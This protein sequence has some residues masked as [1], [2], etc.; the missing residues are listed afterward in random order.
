M[1]EPFPACSAA[2]SQSAEFSIFETGRPLSFLAQSNA[3]FSRLMPFL[4]LIL[5][6]LTLTA[7][8]AHA[9]LQI[10]GRTYLRSPGESG[11]SGEWVLYEKNAPRNEASRR[12]LT[13]KVL[14]QLAGAS[15]SSLSRLP[16]VTRTEARG[17]YAVVTFSGDATAA[18]EGAKRLKRLPGI[19]SAEPMLARQ[20]QPRLVPDDPYFAYN[21]SNPG[22]QWHLRN[23]GENG[24]TAGIDLNVVNTWDAFLGGGIRIGIL[25]DGLETAH[26][27]LAPNI[28]LINDRD[29]N[30]LDDDPSPG[31]G[32]FHGT[33][34]AGVAAARGSNGVGVSG[35]APRATLVGMRLIAAPTTDADE[36]DAFAFRNDIIQVKSSSWGPFDNAFGYGGP[37]V[38]SQA[39]LA[40]AAATGRGGLGTVF[41]WAAGNGN[42]SG[43]DSN[44][45]G[46]AASPY[47]I[48]VSAIRDNGQASSYS[49]PGANIL[50]CAPSNG[51]GQGVTTTDIS[52]ASGYNAGTGQDYSNGDYTLSFGGT[53]SATP[54][55]AGVVALMLQAN[56]GLG[57]RDVQEILLSSATK[58]DA[59]DGGW[60]TNGAGFSF[61]HRYG[62]GLVNA[63]AATTMAQGWTNL[64]PRE[65]RT[66]SAPALNLAIPDGGQAGLTHTFTVDAADNLRLEHVTVSVKATHP[67]RGQLEWWL[68]SPSGVSVRLARARGNDTGAN[69]DWTFMTTH[70]WG[71]RSEG[72]WKLQVYDND[73][74]DAGTLD[75]AAI[76]FHGTPPTGSLPAPVITSSLIIVGREGAEMQHQ[77]T[78]SNAAT[79]FGALG[80]PAGVS[81][82]NST[83]ALFGTPTTTGP[84]YGLV[85]AANTTGTTV[86]NAVFF[87]LPADP[88]LSDA[89]EQP[90]S[91][92]IV[93]F[94]YANWFS[95]SAI[96]HDGVD[97]AQ[98]GPAGHDEYSGVEFTAVGPVRL[99]FRWKVSS[100][101]G[102]DYLVL[103]VDGYVKAYITG[104]VDW[105][106]VSQDIGPGTHNIDIYYLKDEA[107]TAGL[108]AGWVDELTLTPITSAPVVTGGTVQAYENTALRHQVEASN[109][110][111]SYQATGLPSGL[112]IS[113]ATGLI[114]GSTSVTGTH[115]VLIEAAN[116]FGI[117][118]ATLTLVVGSLAEGLAA[119]LDA[120]A[121]IITSSGDLPWIHQSLYSSDGIDAARSGAISD[122]QSSVMST[123]VTGPARVSFYW[124]VS[125]EAGYDYLRFYIDDVEQAAISGEVGWTLRELTLPAGVHTLKWSFIKDDFVRSGLDSGFVDRLHVNPDADLDG[126]YADDEARFGT[127]DQDGNAV[128]R[129]V[130]FSSGGQMTLQ[131]PSVAGRSY[132]IQQSLDDMKTWTTADTVQATGSV[133]SWIDSQSQETGRKFYRVSSP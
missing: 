64:P 109:A 33:A 18:V 105:T 108:D 91:L 60:V 45:D 58:N 125:S 26:P 80:L 52:G 42:L 46:W 74:T 62:A 129:S 16:G 1:K 59:N 126:F 122:L 68:T 73:L 131:F 113:P 75:E 53:S 118:S 112:Q 22:Y 23:T 114:Y 48:A 124:G 40:D 120:P 111:T 86:E 14:V 51:G 72:A 104:E 49:E 115:S 21:V 94:G 55:V 83:G 97:A 93:P 27:D 29:F 3:P 103:A 20:M 35:V 8:L 116:D 130:I 38:L 98:S 76:T 43:D 88:A 56:P 102:Y 39:A 6:A 65:T 100:E 87:V 69:L 106:E 133:S 119:S 95:Q 101:Q 85:F 132:V 30:D 77:V 17:S 99:G 50:V 63:Q 61:H 5:L 41:L 66:L 121:Q 96:S 67:Y 36:A 4:R 44:Y 37:G 10:G 89:V 117:G 13:R 2:P 82:N 12:W 127:S 25:D 70:F 54:A 31:P 81:I 71:E 90:A 92:K 7:S 79:S 57:Y 24:A 28:D 32:N 47:A 15:A 123:Q 110:P 9:Q 84:H 78:A 19:N 128:P 107:V 11:I 34:C